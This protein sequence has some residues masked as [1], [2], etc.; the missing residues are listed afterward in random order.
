MVLDGKSSQEYPVHAR[1]P[2][3]SILG[4]SLLLLCINGLLDYVICKIAIY[5]VDTTLYFKCDKASDLWE[6]LEVASELESDL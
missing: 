5:A 6:Q 2:Q 4:L 3:G 1:D